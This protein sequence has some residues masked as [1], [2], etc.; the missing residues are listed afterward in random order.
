M[1]RLRHEQELF[2][3]AETS[4]GTRA[5]AALAAAFVGDSTSAVRL[6]AALEDGN[7]VTALARAAVERLR[8]DD[9]SRV[10]QAVRAVCGTGRTSRL[11]AVR[12]RLGERAASDER[13]AALAA[14][15]AD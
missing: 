5:R 6:G 10:A 2:A 1:G 12:A 7:G 9:E 13:A 8:D 3:A 11:D 4:A 14:R 15:L